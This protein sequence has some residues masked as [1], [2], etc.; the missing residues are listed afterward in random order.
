MYFSDIRVST[1]ATVG[2]FNPLANL[3]LADEDFEGSAGI[4]ADGTSFAAV[5]SGFTVT[6]PSG[7]HVDPGLVSIDTDARGKV[8]KMESRG[9]PVYLDYMAN[10]AVTAAVGSNTVLIDFHVKHD[11]MGTAFAP[12]VRN[13]TGSGIAVS[14]QLNNKRFIFFNG[15]TE[16]AVSAE[17]NAWHHI[18]VIIDYGAANFT[19]F[20]NGNPVMQQG[21]FRQA[22][23]PEDFGMISFSVN[24]E[25][26]MWL[27]DIK[28]TYF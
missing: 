5:Q 4:F 1:S 3:L 18:R 20:L 6:M 7:L 26:T 24:G 8:L 15:S 13:S 16:Q 21:Q 10:A 11:G 27:D 9:G 23:S 28:I 17:A 19:L 12:Y 2:I 22:L 25:G 14:S